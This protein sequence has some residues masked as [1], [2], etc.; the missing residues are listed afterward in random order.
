LQL[1]S[2]SK[3][4]NVQS[5][6]IAQNPRNGKFPWQFARARLDQVPDRT[7]SADVKGPDWHHE[8]NRHLWAYSRY[9]SQLNPGRQQLASGEQEDISSVINHPNFLRSFMISKSHK[10]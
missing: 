2:G 7:D 1:F 8:Y 5:P 6:A 9:S 4:S 3:N 10:A